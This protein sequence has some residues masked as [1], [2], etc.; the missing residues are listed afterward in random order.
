MDKQVQEPLTPHRAISNSSF[1]LYGLRF[2]HMHAL[3]LKSFP[4]SSEVNVRDGQIPHFCQYLDM[5]ILTF[6]DT[7]ILPIL[8]ILEGWVFADTEYRHHF[9]I[10]DTYMSMTEK[11]V[12][13]SDTDTSIGPSLVNVN[14]SML[15]L[16]FWLQAPQSQS[17][18]GRYTCYRFSVYLKGLLYHINR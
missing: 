4:T 2:P 11:S 3:R 8:M 15:T 9:S 6:A 10:A 13:I 12:D 7:P 5:P 17:W 1:P 14:D 16:P 18:N